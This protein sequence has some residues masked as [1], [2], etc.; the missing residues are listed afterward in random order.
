MVKLN[1]YSALD[2]VDKYVIASLLG[3]Y[4]IF[5]FVYQFY[6]DIELSLEIF[7]GLV[8]STIFGILIIFTKFNKKINI[9]VDENKIFTLKTIYIFLVLILI[10]KI[11]TVSWSLIN[12]DLSVSRDEIWYS[13]SREEAIGGRSIF[14]FLSIFTSAFIV[15]LFGDMFRR[16][17]NSYKLPL[18]IV[19]AYIS[20]EILQIAITTVYRS[21]IVFEIVFWIFFYNFY[22]KKINLNFIK[23]SIFTVCVLL[24]LS[25]GAYFRSKTEGAISLIHGMRGLVTVYE[26]DS[27]RSMIKSSQLN[28]ELGIQLF[29]NLISWVPR[30]LWENKPTT[31]FSWRVSE[32]LYGYGEVGVTTW[33]RTFSIA[34]EGYLQF[35][36]LGMIIWTVI[37][38]YLYLFTKRIADSCAFSFPIFIKLWVGMPLIIRGDLSAFFGSFWTAIIVVTF[39]GFIFYILKGGFK[40][41]V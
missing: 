5:P 35:G 28:F 39:F 1:K 6:T 29:Y 21:P 38:S 22:I 34:G 32:L 36:V 11:L 33:V 17:L 2:I 20:I 12:I 37:F 15:I 40:Y 41:K 19:M 24:Y 18:L 8:L 30:I 4:L 7:T 14:G 10:I 23:I 3:I 26:I 31:S 13:E 9:R 27:I 16:K 25:W